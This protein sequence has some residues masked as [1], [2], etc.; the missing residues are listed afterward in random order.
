M[1]SGDGD[2]YAQR[3]YSCGCSA[4]STS[5]RSSLRDADSRPRRPQRH[6]SADQLRKRAVG[7]QGF[8]RFGFF[9]R[10]RG[11]APAMHRCAAM[12]R[13]IILSLLLIGVLPTSSC[14]CSGSFTSSPLSVGISFVSVDA[15]LLERDSW[16]SFSRRWSARTATELDDPASRRGGLFLWLV[17]W[18]VRVSSLR[19]A[20]RPGTISRLSS[21]RNTANSDAA[22]HI[23]TS[24][25]D[26]VARARLS[27]FD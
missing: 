11:S 14:R 5:S 4:S 23:L 3:G 10:S 8:N 21:F 6:P 20:I 24:I 19:V 2:Q 15:L 25:A 7:D 22:R 26:V 16:R 13:R 27:L 12:H 18:S 9:R 17:S 1:S